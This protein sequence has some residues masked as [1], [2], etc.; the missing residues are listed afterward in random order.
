[1]PIA[2]R[3]HRRHTLAI[4][5]AAL[6]GQ[7][8]AQDAG[9]DQAALRRASAHLFVANLGQ[10]ASPAAFRIQSAGAAAWLGQD[11]IALDLL[12]AERSSA[13]AADPGPG[14]CEPTHY[15]TARAR[16]SFVNAAPTRPVGEEPNP[17]R[18]HFY[19][20]NDPAAWRQD[21]PA[22]GAVRWSQP[23][24]GIDVRAR[25][26]ETGLLE[27]DLVVASGVDPGTAVLRW[28]GIERI[29]RHENGALEVLTATGPLLQSAPVAWQPTADGEQLPVTVA[30]ELLEDGCFRFRIAA[31]RADLPVVI[32]PV[33]T[34]HGGGGDDNA[35]GVARDPSG[36]VVAAGLTTAPSAGGM[37]V[38]VSCFDFTLPWP[39]VVWTTTYG[40]GLDDRALAVDADTVGYF[41]VV[42]VTF[43]TD[44]PTTAGAPQPT[45]GGAFD[46]F[47]LQLSPAG[48]PTFATY[49]GG[50]VTDWCCCV[51][52]DAQ[53]QATVGGYSNSTNL[54]AVNAFQQNNA[55]LR[56]AFVVRFAPF[57][58]GIVYATYLG[59]S[60]NSGPLAGPTGPV[61][62][63]NRVMGLDLDAA[64][65]VL[66]AG[67]T[68]STNFPVT[69]NARQPNLG[70]GADAFVTILDPS[71]PPSAQLVYST[72]LGIA[73]AEGAMAARFG[74]GSTIVVG[75]YT[76][77]PSFPTTAGAF[78]PVFIGPVGFNDAFL[79]FLDPSQAPAS[80][81]TYGT[82]FGGLHSTGPDHY[83]SVT[84]LSV[85][86]RGH[87]TVAG[88]RC[89]DTPWPPHV[90]AFQPVHGGDRDGF[91][92]RLRPLG[93]AAADLTYATFLGGVGIYNDLLWDLEPEPDGGVAI[94]GRT[95]SPAIAG[96]AGTL[97]GIGDMLVGT[98][99]VLPVGL[100]RGPGSSGYCAGGPALGTVMLEV[101]RQ[102]V[103]GAMFSYLI[104]GAPPGLLGLVGLGF[105]PPPPALP[106]GGALVCI[107]PPTVLTFLVS[108]ARG[109]AAL[110][111]AVPP[112]W[113]NT[114]GIHAQALWL[115]PAA[116]ASPFTSS[117][118][119][120]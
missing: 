82:F 23:W 80:Q 4:L 97:G 20:G 12:R 16:L 6:A 113:P 74:P 19:L 103:A 81:L 43:S 106:L 61:D 18:A 46:G 114:L 45:F 56:D 39:H 79:V 47:V 13:P 104:G 108:G 36:R 48:T 2:W 53:L 86:A 105:G 58:T 54:P 89:S 87:A 115:A 85:D 34:Y 111:L 38:L 101:D 52:V 84:A 95:R 110:P 9:T 64:G 83:D 109:E 68:T 120:F 41:T 118:T 40:G 92:A 116:C 67:H 66:L 94:A 50:P 90:G 37:D 100:G 117:A 65:R 27:Y 17:A 76:Y 24:P 21:V 107:G 70:G 7:M 28:D 26:H 44:F 10:W 69:A 72:Y 55:G 29:E 93:A 32:D 77:S 3:A 31:A 5:L 11:G 25:A 51:E 22:F 60:G 102:P 57:G 42:G 35:H 14:A 59:G 63:D 98:M 75:G 96:V 73:N 112:G 62:G 8:P 91:V 30:V 119:V 49:Y 1:M 71:Q 88:F 99:G 78:Q 15:T 33:L